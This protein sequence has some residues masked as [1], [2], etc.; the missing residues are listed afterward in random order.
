MKNTD[1]RIEKINKQIELLKKQKKEILRLKNSKEKENLENL[2]ESKKKHLIRLG[3]ILDEAGIKT[4]RE[5]RKLI[6]K[7]NELVDETTDVEEDIETFEEEE[8]NIEANE[9]I[10]DEDYED[11]HIEIEEIKEEKTKKTKKAKVIEEENITIPKQSRKEKFG[12]S[13]K[14][15]DISKSNK[16]ARNK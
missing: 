11:D 15:I 7:F 8:I 3:K 5:V 4:Q 1:K 6:Y 13:K 10:V 9:K 12:N 16:K 14:K 2:S